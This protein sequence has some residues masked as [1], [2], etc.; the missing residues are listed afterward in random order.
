ML[1]LSIDELNLVEIGVEEAEKLDVCEIKELF[2]A[3]D[4]SRRLEQR[5]RKENVGI[6]FFSSSSS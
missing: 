2:N 1:G 6:L 5:K 4:A 3:S